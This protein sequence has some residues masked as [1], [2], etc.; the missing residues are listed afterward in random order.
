MEENRVL[1]K[2]EMN[3]IRNLGRKRGLDPNFARAFADYCRTT[4]DLEISNIFTHKMVEEATARGCAPGK[5][6]GSVITQERRMELWA[7]AEA[8]AKKPFN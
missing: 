1:T 5:P 3:R 6:L 8:E 4:L 7:E 2:Q